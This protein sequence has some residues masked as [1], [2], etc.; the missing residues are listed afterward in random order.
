MYCFS[1]G[2]LG[3]PIGPKAQVANV[4]RSSDDLTQRSV[5]CLL[6]LDHKHNSGYT[7]QLKTVRNSGLIVFAQTMTNIINEKME[8]QSC[9]L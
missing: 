1:V 5:S 7:V 4:L 6:L 8:D 2:P 3:D 9:A